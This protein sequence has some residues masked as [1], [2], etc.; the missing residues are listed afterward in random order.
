MPLY[1]SW[2]CAV[3]YFSLSS[4]SLYWCTLFL[5]GEKAF[6]L[7][8]IRPDSYPHFFFLSFSQF[9]FPKVKTVLRSLKEPH[10]WAKWWALFLTVWAQS[11]LFSSLCLTSLYFSVSLIEGTLSFTSF[12]Y[13]ISWFPVHVEACTAG[14]WERPLAIFSHFESLGVMN[15]QSFTKLGKHQNVNF[16][17]T[18]WLPYFL[19]S[20]DTASVWYI[21]QLF[22]CAS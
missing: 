18:G 19:L 13:F 15:K 5:L 16:S 6:L 11:R 4:L 9:H 22:V 1:Y 21:W 7:V 14:L 20:P 10:W 8:K 2:M 12:P 17:Q 3:T